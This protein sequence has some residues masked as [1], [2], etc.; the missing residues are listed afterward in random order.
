MVGR[1]LGSKCGE[2]RSQVQQG[3]QPRW[4][5]AGEVEVDCEIRGITAQGHLYGDNCL[6]KVALELRTL[7]YKM[8]LNGPY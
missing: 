2:N 8:G 1:V 7:G 4:S 5:V 3:L 6:V